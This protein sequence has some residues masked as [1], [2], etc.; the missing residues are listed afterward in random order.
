MADSPAKYRDTRKGL[1]MLDVDVQDEEARLIEDGMPPELLESG[2]IFIPRL[3]MNFSS[4]PEVNSKE[5]HLALTIFE[6]WASQCLPRPCF[7]V[8]GR[9]PPLEMIAY[10]M[11]YTLRTIKK[12][13]EALQQKGMLIVSGDIYDFTPLLEALIAKAPLSRDRIEMER[14]LQTVWGKRQ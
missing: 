5:R 6:E 10:H 8:W 11:G 2:I 7:R 3:L 9:Q 14:M 1:V 12:H 4:L 13:V